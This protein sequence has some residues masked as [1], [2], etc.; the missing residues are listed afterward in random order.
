MT[1]TKAYAPLRNMALFYEL[2]E[3]V[4]TRSLHLP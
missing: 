4:M 1:T 3:R 2:V